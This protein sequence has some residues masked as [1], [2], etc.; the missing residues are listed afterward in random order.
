MAALHM[1]FVSLE[2]ENGPDLLS[3]LHELAFAGQDEKPWSAE[4][5]RQMVVLQGVSAAVA[6]VD[7]IPVGF[8]LWRRV[9]DEAELI[10]I[11][12]VP[13]ARGQGYARHMLTFIGEQLKAAGGEKLF[14]EVRA[15]NA[16]AIDLYRS[17]GFQEIGQRRRYYQ[18]QSGKRVDALCLMLILNNPDADK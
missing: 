8:A 2:G 10:T 15:D 3:H 6:Y 17:S 1:A 4:E 9:L 11:G 16:P 13:A 7:E 14:L 5:F 12:V 18:T